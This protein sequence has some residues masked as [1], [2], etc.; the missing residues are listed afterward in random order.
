[1]TSFRRLEGLDGAG[2]RRRDFF[3]AAGRFLKRDKEPWKP[4]P[5]T[6]R[7]EQTI[8]LSAFIAFSKYN[9]KLRLFNRNT[10]ARRVG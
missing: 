3:A 4:P 1:L 8:P 9:I 10:R 5:E 2:N 6:F 7:E